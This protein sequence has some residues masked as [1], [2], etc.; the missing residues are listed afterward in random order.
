M[1]NNIITI[2][3]GKE[4]G[5][6][7]KKNLYL[8][9]T[10]QT[11]FLEGEITKI[12]VDPGP[13][14]LQIDMGLFGIRNVVT[15]RLFVKK[16]LEVGMK[17]FV[18]YSNW[19][20]KKALN[21]RKDI[22]YTSQYKI[23]YNRLK[24]IPYLLRGRK[25]GIAFGCLRVS[26]TGML[27]KVPGILTSR[28]VIN[29]LRR[30]HVNK[31]KMPYLGSYYFIPIGGHQR[32]FRRKRIYN[33][34]LYF[35]GYL[36]TRSYAY[37]YMNFL[38]R[39]MLHINKSINITLI[40]RSPFLTSIFYRLYVQKIIYL[41]ICTYLRSP[42]RDDIAF[43]DIFSNFLFIFRYSICV[44][45]KKSLF[46]SKDKNFFFNHK[47]DNVS[48][49][50]HGGCFYLLYLNII[51]RNVKLYLHF[52]VNP[53]IANIILGGNRNII[54]TGPFLFN[55]NIFYTRNLRIKRS[56]KRYHK[57]RKMLL[58]DDGFRFTKSRKF[59]A[60]SKAHQKVDLSDKKKTYRF[61]RFK[62]RRFISSKKK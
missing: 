25:A 27:L 38:A 44:L 2:N 21:F 45:D 34:V 35:R 3:K 42:R 62:R 52:E 17:I 12:S 19:V 22:L 47:F 23:S 4:A 26:S 32:D 16:P 51:V 58:Y 29:F 37:K 9:N 57:R 20:S 61:N 1:K 48:V 7:Y 40:D 14:E 11:V 30:P 24:G 36:T 46:L 10:N 50:D 41:F 53:L 55:K 49:L 18:R 43:S 13:I 31:N 60:I 33:K 59:L 54:W 15:P 8:H 6:F 56:Y 28:I 39:E 5:I